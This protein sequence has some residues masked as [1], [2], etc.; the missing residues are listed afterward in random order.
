ML[1]YDKRVS[2][3]WL[4][5]DNVR[6]SCV[7]RRAVRRRR[8]IRGHAVHG[9]YSA[10]YSPVRN[11][12]ASDS[13]AAEARQFLR[14][15]LGLGRG[16]SSHFAPICTAKL[17]RDQSSGGGDTCTECHINHGHQGLSLSLSLTH[18]FLDSLHPKFKTFK[19]TQKQK[20]AK[21]QHLN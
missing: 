13:P 14:Y 9:N 8:A 10:R 6:G 11:R 5:G 19:R 2:N 16:G 1:S 12:S 18:T 21:Q 15:C 17:R 20:N 4:S 3:G 7:A